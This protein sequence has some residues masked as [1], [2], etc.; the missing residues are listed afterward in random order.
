MG[1]TRRRLANIATALP[2]TGAP[3]SS[4]AVVVD[5]TVG[6]PA[7]LRE[8]TYTNVPR[9]SIDTV[10]GQGEAMAHLQ[11]E[12]YVVV[13]DILSTADCS[14]ALDML[15]S[16]L[17]ADGAKRSDPSTWGDDTSFGNNWGHSDF[18]W[19]VRGMPKVRKV[20]EIAHRTDELLVSFDGASLYRPWGL[21]PDWNV[22]AMGL[23]V[24]RRNHDGIPDGYVQG[25]VNLIS[26]S[27]QAGGNVVVPR[28]HKHVDELEAVRA[29]VKPGQSFYEAVAEVRGNR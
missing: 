13:R 28:S 26:T 6:W 21:Q 16:E 23:H 18:L 11:T 7:W 1:S 29:R 27:P 12:G 4:D 17:E 5:A 19:H 10:R 9:F 8:P 20:W 15:W 2:T 25:F 14:D 24:D 22:P 3:A